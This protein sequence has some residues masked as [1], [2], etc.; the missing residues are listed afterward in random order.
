MVG[1]ETK[2]QWLEV[3]FRG[4]EVQAVSEDAI[5]GILGVKERKEVRK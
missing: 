4:E 3:W 5:M 1:V 2:I